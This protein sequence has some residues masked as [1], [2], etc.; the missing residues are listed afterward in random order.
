MASS[1][2]YRQPIVV[3]YN[4]PARFDEAIET[5]SDGEWTIM[6]RQRA[7]LGN[8]LVLCVA[9]AMFSAAASF[10]WSDEIPLQQIIVQYR[11]GT[12]LSG[13]SA[14]RG[15]D[16][17]NALREATDTELT[18]YREMSGD[19]HVLRLPAPLHADEV[20]AITER[21]TRLPD[22]AYAE[23]DRVMTLA[24]SPDDPEY[25]NQ[26]HYFETYGM[27][28]PT[29]W[30]ITT[31]S[32]NIRIAVLDSGITEHV[33]LAGRWIGGY[34]FISSAAWGNDGDGRDADPRDPGDW[35]NAN[36]CFQGSQARSS[37]WHGTHVAGTIGAAG[38]NAIGVAGVNW[39]STIIPV[40]VVGKC[41]GLISDIA[42]GI[43]WAAGLTVSGVPDNPHPARLLN[44]SLGGPGVCSQTYQN[45]I[46]AVNAIG[47]I[48]VVAAG[49]NGANLNTNTYQP[50]NC[51][52]VIT[53]AATD[54][55]GDRAIYSN[56][57]TIVKI[58]APGG[59]NIPILQDG[60]LSTSNAGP[61]F[62]TTDSYR[63]SQGTSMAAPHVSGV[64]AL[65]LSLDPMLTASEVL[66]I[67]QTTARPFRAGSACNTSNCGSGILDAGAAVAL[68]APEC[69]NDCSGHGVCTVGKCVCETGWGG[70][71]CSKQVVPVPSASTWGLVMLCA[72][73]IV[74]T[75]L[76]SGRRIEAT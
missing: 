53:V 65:L 37:S 12:D 47:A 11:I 57:G 7:T 30:D 28:A 19:A 75:I 34:D 41:G 24:M 40:R 33:D 13:R 31:G 23:P 73:G 64:I 32:T 66:S 9:A 10:A 48:V 22:V 2:F 62:P 38:N 35:V 55:S 70:V 16:R 68:I 27:N 54:R 42:D 4:D 52:G 45:A 67:L 29:A 8:R 21:I 6:K 61:T 1:I 15:P 71:D 3:R 36:E 25:G 56:Y 44:L 26:W 59:E 60:V 14:A 46:D 49:N 74:S 58:A 18:Y 63:Y 76:R 51:S 43:R 50:A 72:M 69:P 39:N 5:S 20:A 17:M